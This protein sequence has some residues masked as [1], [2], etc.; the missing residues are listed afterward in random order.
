MYTEDDED[1]AGLI[2]TNDKRSRGSKTPRRSTSAEFPSD[3]SAGEQRDAPAKRT[4]K[5][6]AATTAH[7][8]GWLMEHVHHPYPTESVL[9][10][11]GTSGYL[12]QLADADAGIDRDEKRGMCLRTNLNMSQVSNWFINA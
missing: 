7:L 10:E 3:D 1:G 9:V 2:E 12:V 4:G 8:K 5:L 11:I 6:P